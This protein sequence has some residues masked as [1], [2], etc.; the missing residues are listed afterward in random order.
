MKIN[1]LGGGPA[2]LYAAY[3]LKRSKPDAVVNVYEQNDANTT[4]GFGVVFSDQ[5]LEFLRANDEETLDVITQGLETWRDIELR[6]HGESICIDGVGFTA[7]A[8]LKLLEIL[9]ERAL[10]VGAVL[11]NGKVIQSVQE[12]DDADLVIAADG[13]NSLVRRTF[14]RELGSSVDHFQNHFA[15]F[16]ADRPFERLTQTFKEV[17]QGFFNAHHYRY[18]PTMSTFLVEVDAPT[19]ERVGFANMSEEESKQYCEKVFAD[20]LQGASL[21]INKSHWRRFPI[22]NNARWSAGKYVLVG[23][24][25]RTAHFSIGSGTRLAMEDVQA[26]VA[27]VVDGTGDIAQALQNYEQNRRPAV[28]KIG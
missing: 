4:F 26:L 3:L 27:A 25:L 22:I 9:R 23:D 13:V 21:I 10:S 18:A 1:I 20:E 5:A 6:V 2:G 7:I 12:I 24:A 8:R 16:G 15:W 28:E 17:S 14:E 11:H 19:F